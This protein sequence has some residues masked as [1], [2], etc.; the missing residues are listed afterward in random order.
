MAVECPSCRWPTAFEEL[1]P[2]EDPSILL[3]GT[4]HIAQ[5]AVQIIAIR[6]SPNSRRAPDYKNDVPEECYKTNG[7]NETLAE[8]LED[9]EY[10]SA[11]FDELLGEGDSGLLELATG[12]YVVIALPSTVR[13]RADPNLRSTHRRS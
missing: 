9:F 3:A 5:S 8:A 4:A 12:T 10:L 2:V 6:I 13:N 1:G 11:D 7:L